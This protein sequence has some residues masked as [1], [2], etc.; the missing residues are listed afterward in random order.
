MKTKSRAG[1]ARTKNG[2]SKRVGSGRLVSLAPSECTE[3]QLCR[4]KRDNYDYYHHWILTDSYRITIAAQKI[5]EKPT[6]SITIP[7]HI[8]NAL[9]RFYTTPQPLAQG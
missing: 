5:G 4:I 9:V 6:Q 3:N 1:K 7:R 8:F 2:P